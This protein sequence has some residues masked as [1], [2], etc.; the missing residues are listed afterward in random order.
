MEK[1]EKKKHGMTDFY[2]NMLETA[3]KT[4]NGYKVDVEKMFDGLRKS[5]KH[6]T[7]IGAGYII[8]EKELTE[9]EVAE[10]KRQDD[11]RTAA[12]A[13][14]IGDYINKKII[15]SMKKEGYFKKYVKC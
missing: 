15:E 13:K 12:G 4:D 3:E 7:K 6:V 14:A 9:E 8:S 5:G 11:E 1:E 2:E 10:Y